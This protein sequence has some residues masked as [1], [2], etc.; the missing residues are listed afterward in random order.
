MLMQNDNKHRSTTVCWWNKD[1]T[2]TYGNRNQYI[3][4]IETFHRHR[5]QKYNV[6][7]TASS[8]AYLGNLKQC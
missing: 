7:G 2:G 6:E 8:K 4:G 3:D 1:G 5:V